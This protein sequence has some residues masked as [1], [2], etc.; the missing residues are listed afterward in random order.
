MKLCS[1]RSFFIYFFKKHIKSLCS[2]QYIL[3]PDHFPFFKAQSETSQIWRRGVSGRAVRRWCGWWWRARWGGRQETVQLTDGH[4]E[5][6][7]SD[8]AEPQEGALTSKW[9]ATWAAYGRRV[10]LWSNCRIR[11][12]HP[13]WRAEDKTG[14]TGL[15]QD[16]G[17]SWRSLSWPQRKADAESSK[18]T[19]E[20]KK[21]TWSSETIMIVMMFIAVTIMIT[22][23]WFYPCD[24][25]RNA[26][27]SLL[28]AQWRAGKGL[29]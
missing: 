26:S 22:P 15:A 17:S 5:E 2:L 24:L 9:L 25:L 8:K 29:S 12:Q 13:A 3:I 20:T 16:H 6:I 28:L 18:T 23:T 27:L 14:S 7:T 4:P 11:Q 19:A 10:R 21:T 1:N